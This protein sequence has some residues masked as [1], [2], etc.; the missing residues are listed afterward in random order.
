MSSVQTRHMLYT[1]DDLSEEGYQSHRMLL[2][3]VYTVTR[4]SHAWGWLLS[5]QLRYIWGFALQV[6]PLPLLEPTIETIQYQGSG[7]A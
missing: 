7:E 1:I 5:N 3:H 6:F 4:I 2:K